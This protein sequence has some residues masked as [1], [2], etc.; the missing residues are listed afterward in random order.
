MQ[1]QYLIEN[2]LNS[3][4]DSGD[5]A[6]GEGIDIITSITDLD[7]ITAS[8]TMNWPICPLGENLWSGHVGYL[9]VPKYYEEIKNYEKQYGFPSSELFSKWQSGTLPI[10]DT[11]I[12]DWLALY[13]QVKEF[14]YE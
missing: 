7:T 1:T 2:K 12:N 9:D 6:T 3:A 14:I 5:I 8:G 13:L 4:F 11:K 10:V